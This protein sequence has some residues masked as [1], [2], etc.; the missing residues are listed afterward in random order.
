M[1]MIWKGRALSAAEAARVRQ[2]PES[3]REPVGGAGAPPAVVDLD[4]AWHG[5]HWL[6]TGSAW[7]GEGP[8]ALAVLGG[9]QVDEGDGDTPRLLLDAANVAAVATALDAVG[10][11]ELRKRYDPHAMSEAEIY[12]N[13]WDDEA[14][15]TDLAPGFELLKQ[16]YTHAAAR[17]CWVLQTI[18]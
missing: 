16:L 17:D 1:G 9:E 12:P 8:L 13:I 5:I 3:L 18:T 4:K 10:V 6:L 14:F 15:D 2:N 11:D 7:D